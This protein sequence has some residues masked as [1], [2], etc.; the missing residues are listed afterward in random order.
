MYNYED[1]RNELIK[2]LPD[3]KCS[4]CGKHADGVYRLKGQVATYEFYCM[5]CAKFYKAI[6]VI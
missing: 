4:K 5:A 3:T 1:A 2:H 6:G